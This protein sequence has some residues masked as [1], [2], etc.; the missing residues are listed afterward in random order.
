M[1]DL[2]C[3]YVHMHGEARV[4]L[5]AFLDHFQAYVFDTGSLTDWPVGGPPV[6]PLSCRPDLCVSAGH[7]SSG[8]GVCTVDTSLSEF[9]L[10][11]LISVF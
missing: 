4:R 11:G 8:P 7:H 10:P 2:H 9:S 5:G 6:S 3:T 1:F